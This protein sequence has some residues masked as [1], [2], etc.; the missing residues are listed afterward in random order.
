MGIEF[1]YL[2]GADIDRLALDEDAILG[3]V[4]DGL[5]AQGGGRAVIEPRTHLFPGGTGRAAISTC[6]AARS[7]R[8]GW[9]G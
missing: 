3:A 2:S 1:T 5:S 8:W 4:E 7:P 6:C 9:R